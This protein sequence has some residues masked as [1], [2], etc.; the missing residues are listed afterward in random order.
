MLFY[1]KKLKRY[2]IRGIPLILF[3]PH[4]SNHKQYT[5]EYEPTIGKLIKSTH[6]NIKNAYPEDLSSAVC[7]VFLLERVSRYCPW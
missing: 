7:Y 5:V 2:G 6:L 4:L 1:V 3:E